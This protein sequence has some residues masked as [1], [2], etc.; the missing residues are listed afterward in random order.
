MKPYETSRQIGKIILSW[1]KESTAFVLLYDNYSK[2]L[3]LRAPNQ[4]E[5]DRWVRVIQYFILLLKKSKG[6]LQETDE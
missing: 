5:R 6:V 1:K 3:E 2:S 4:Y